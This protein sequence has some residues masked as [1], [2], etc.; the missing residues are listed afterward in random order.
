M[1]NRV[2]IFVRSA[3][4]T[5]STSR[6]VA[7][8]NDERDVSSSQAARGTQP[9]PHAGKMPA[10]PAE[11]PIT[12]PIYDFIFSA[13]SHQLQHARKVLI[14]NCKGITDE[15]RTELLVA[16]DHQFG[17]LNALAMQPM[18]QGRRS[19]LSLHTQE[20]TTPAFAELRR[21][22]PKTHDGTN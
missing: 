21:G 12:D 17:R 5:A 1:N 16:V 10:L 15:E 7:T 8:N 13:D 18:S 14:P 2:H 22:K 9:V 19:L 3:K 20:E 4:P 11:N 6:G